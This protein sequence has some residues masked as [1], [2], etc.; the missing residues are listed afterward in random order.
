M[1]ISEENSVQLFTFQKVSK[2]MISVG[3]LV[4]GCIS[5]ESFTQRTNVLYRKTY[6]FDK[7]SLGIVL[8][9][10]SQKIIVLWFRP[11]QA[12]HLAI[13]VY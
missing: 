11:P 1:V 3:D 13:K 9:C 10:K 2:T 5:S 7:N 12:S 4:H 6:R 8:G